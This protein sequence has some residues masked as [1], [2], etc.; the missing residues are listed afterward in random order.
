MFCSAYLVLSFSAFIRPLPKSVEDI[1]EV[2][3]PIAV[4][5]ENSKSVEKKRGRCLTKK[6]RF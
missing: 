1:D 6:V 2:S 3:F 4:E 5:L